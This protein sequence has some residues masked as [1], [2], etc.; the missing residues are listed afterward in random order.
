MLKR[1]SNL[2][3]VAVSYVDHDIVVFEEY[4]QLN[5]TG[6]YYLWKI[7]DKSLTT[8]IDRRPIGTVPVTQV[9]RSNQKLFINYEVGDSYIKLKNLTLK[10]G[11]IRRLNQ[12]IAVFRL[13]LKITCIM[14]KLITQ[15]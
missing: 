6:I 12:K 9:A 1:T 13:S 8:L 7:K 14:Y 15:L 2:T 4:D 3:H 5:Q 11:L 10:Q